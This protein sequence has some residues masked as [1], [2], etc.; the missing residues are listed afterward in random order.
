[1][2]TGLVVALRAEARAMLGRVRWEGADKRGAD[3]RGAVI[4]QSIILRTPSGRAEIIATL[5]GVGMERAGSAAS[6]LLE[7]GATSLVSAGI[8]GAL[9]PDL[10]AG[11]IVLATSVTDGEGR[12]Q[13]VNEGALV[14]ARGALK[15]R[16]M[17]FTEGAVLSTGSAVLGVSSK[18]R[19]FKESGAICVDMESGG[20][21]DMA[22]KGGVP[23]LVIRAVC[24]RADEGISE[25]LYACLD[26]EG[27][28]RAG[29]LIGNCLKRPSL[30][31]E[32]MRLKKSFDTATASLGRAWR[33]LVEEGVFSAPASAKRGPVQ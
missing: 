9:S 10:E 29:H 21:A 31:G 27:G 6:L 14:T 19:L 20:V 3:K 28:V 5:S 16:G 7:K 4:S 33:A 26:E 11:V 2:S 18:A 22:L 12:S 24:D 30:V 15:R 32:M 13:E 25:D 23:F 17:A 1:V 8:S